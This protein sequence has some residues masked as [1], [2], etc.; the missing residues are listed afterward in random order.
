MKPPARLVLL[1]IFLALPLLEI[2]ILIKVG[3]VAGFWPTVALVLVTAIVGAHVLHAQGLATLERASDALAAGRP[4]V[5][6]VAEGVFLLLAGA[7]LVTPGILTDLAG[8]LLLVPAV[9]RS[10]IRLAV[11]RLVGAADLDISVFTTH[12]TA[13]G[14]PPQG[15]ST[16]GRR[17]P[18]PGHDIVIDG[19]FE[20]LEERPIRKPNGDDPGTAG[21]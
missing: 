17:R 9:R 12:E 3:Q 21:R 8:L 11:S 18:P 20:R 2:A 14:E 13:A 6:P 7:F 15:R 10:I 1:L 16:T 19:E 4:P 5:E